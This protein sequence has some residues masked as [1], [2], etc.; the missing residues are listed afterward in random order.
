MVKREKT[1]F[2]WVRQEAKTYGPGEQEY[3]PFGEREEK[4]RELMMTAALDMARRVKLVNEEAAYLTPEQLDLAWERVAPAPTNDLEV[5]FAAYLFGFPL[6]EYLVHSN[7]ME[8][9][10]FS[11]GDGSSLAVRHPLAEVTAFPIDSVKKRVDPLEPPF[12]KAVASTV[13]KQ[14]SSSLAARREME[15]SDGEKP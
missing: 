15:E 4:Q 10:V 7:G 9:C 14:I 5:L 3:R 11:D 1:E 6:G 13:I 2:G 8:W 12:F